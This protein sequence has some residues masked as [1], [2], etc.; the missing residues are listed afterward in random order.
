MSKRIFSKT[1]LVGF[2]LTAIAIALSGC[3]DSSS[4]PAGTSG[5]VVD[6][7]VSGATVIL[8]SNDDLV[9]NATDTTRTTT[10]AQG[11]FSFPAGS[12][13][14][15]TCAL[16]GTDITTGAAFV[17]ELKAPPG[18]T[19]I[20]PLTTLVQAT[21]DAAPAGGKPTPAE[22]SANI[23]TKLNLGTT[24]LLTTDPVAV[25]A[26][27][28]ALTQTTTAVQT[29]LVQAANNV[30]AAATGLPVSAAQTA[31]LFSS[32]V[33]GVASAVASSSVNVDL[34][35]TTTA[36]ATSVTTLVT[37]AISKTV[38]AVQTNTT[39]AATVVGVASLAPASVAAA[40]ATNVATVT[41]VVASTSAVTLVA[42]PV[43]GVVPVSLSAQTDTTASSTTALVSGL[44]TTNAAE[45]TTSNSV[46]DIVALASTVT[47]ALESGDAT[48]ASTL[49]NTQITAVIVEVPTVVIEPVTAPVL[50]PVPNVIVLTAPQL[51]GVLV[52]TTSVD[53]FFPVT[54]SG[55]LTSA[56]MTLAV[57]GTPALSAAAV[58]FDITEEAPGTRQ[59]KLVIDSATLT[60]NGGVISVTVPSTAKLYVWGMNTAGVVSQATLLNAASNVLTSTG[61]VMSV[62]W[63]S[64][65]SSLSSQPGFGNLS[66]LTGT[67]NVVAA[68]SGAPLAIQT[69]AQNAVVEAGLRSVSIPDVASVSGQGASFRVTVTGSA[70]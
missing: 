57:S 56:A 27:N 37:D 26:T 42:A 52:G 70:L 12:G 7:Y 58:G 29:L 41:Q 69:T 55:P 61:G 43:A 54:V 22:A 2:S 44:L 50:P 48:S 40:A 51:N 13:S 36:G 3:G 65:L 62:N 15:M 5:K 67:F 16:G 60:N 64:A 9:C 4:L 66:L 34:T 23:A 63:T 8:D 17:G 33:S 14:H 35:N 20:T 38:T 32:A 10:D 59:L 6:G 46:A 47:N 31:A 19:Q 39:A 24:N 45:A 11:N 53:G 1:G 18:A 30:A 25:A 49:V 68:L 28:P 21:I